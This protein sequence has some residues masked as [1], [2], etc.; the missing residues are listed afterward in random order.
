VRLISATDLTLV[1]ANNYPAWIDVEVIGGNAPV[2]YG[3]TGNTGITGPTGITGATGP[4]GHTGITGHTG[5]TGITGH[6]GPTGITG[7]TGPTGITGHTGPTGPTGPAGLGVIAS[8]VKAVSNTNLQISNNMDI[9][10][11]NIEALF[12]D[13]ITL[14]AA[15]TQFTLQSGRT[16]RIRANPGY[17]TFSTAYGYA[18]FQ[19]NKLT[20]T[21]SPAGL[22]GTP[23]SYLPQ[24]TPLIFAS[25]GTLEYVVQLTTIETY[26]IRLIG[27]Q[28]LTYIAYNNYPAWL[29]I[30]VIGGNAPITLGVTGPPG[31]S[32][33]DLNGYKTYY[34]AGN[35]GVYT[36]DPQTTLEVVGD[37][38]ITNPRGTIQLNGNTSNNIGVGDNSILSAVTSGIQN[39]AFGANTLDLITSGS[40][41]TAFGYGALTNN[42]SGLYNTAI[43]YNAFTTGN[44]INNSTA[45]G[46]NSN[47]TTNNQIVLGTLNET[48][49]IPGKLAVGK[50][51]VTAGYA[52]DVSGICAATNFAITSDYRIK[53]NIVPLS[54][55]KL[56]DDLRPVEYDLSGGE[57]NM[58]FIAHEVQDVFPFLVNHVKDGENIQSINYVGLIALLVKEIQELKK[59]VSIL[60]KK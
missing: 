30:Q 31:P 11:T 60:E 24:A 50:T 59:R 28:D 4:T 32:I 15:K 36:T 48:V 26:S 5:P 34:S 23:V 8:Y 22:V 54:E 21:G 3:V 25:T 19:I 2:M 13:D 1:G 35:V 55:T 27:S 12:S 18:N 41:N 52:V 45:I 49:Y 29:D 7:Y 39:T 38:R 56:V 17:C 44:V 57:H 51:T 58:G 6:T 16:Y 33:W 14:N 47:P 9:S 20:N 42:V 40:Y 37:V 46:Y 53:H 10:F 43:G